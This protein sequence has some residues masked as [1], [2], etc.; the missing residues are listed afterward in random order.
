[1]IEGLVR[2]AEP[3]AAAQEQL[4]LGLDI[5]DA[6]L[7]VCNAGGKAMCAKADLR[8][9]FASHGARPVVD[10]ILMVDILEH[11]NLPVADAH[12]PPHRLRASCMERELRHGVARGGCQAVARL[13]RSGQKVLLYDGAKLRR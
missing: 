12:V 4:V 8:W 7:R 3:A 2:K 13:V 9:L 10:G 1:M 5:S 11:I 6:K